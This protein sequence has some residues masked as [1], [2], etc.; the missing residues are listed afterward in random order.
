MATTI[1]KFWLSNPSYW[2]TPAD[3]RSTVDKLIWE[4]WREFDWST[5]DELGQIIY[6][7]QFMR[8]FSRCSVDITEKDVELSRRQAADIAD[9]ADLTRVDS[10]D[11]VW[12]LMPW[13]HLG[14]YQKVFTAIAG[15]QLSDCAELRRFYADTYMKAYDDTTVAAAVTLCDIDE[16]YDAAALC[17]SHPDTINLQSANVSAPLVAPLRFTEPVTISLSGGVDSMLM[18]ALLKR[19]GVD[20]IAVHIVYGNRTIS[21]DE[22]R[23]ISK[24]C[25]RLN[26]PLYVYRI[27]WLRRGLCDRAFYERMTRDLR[28][29]VYRA[30]GRPVLLGH[31]QEDVIENVWTNFAR[32]TN[33][34]NLGKFSMR[35]KESGVDIWRPWLTIS[36][37]LIYSL[38]GSMGI[39]HLKNTT[40]AWSNRG[41]FR[42]QFYGA[43]KE[44]YGEHVDDK[45]LEVAGRLQ[46]QN[47]VIH[48]LVY[49]PIINSWCPKERTLNISGVVGVDLGGD[50]WL[51]IFSDL[52]HN[53]LG[54]SKP[55]YAACVNF[56]K[57]V[58]R[59]LS[60]GQKVVLSKKMV[61]CFCSSASA[62]SLIKLDTL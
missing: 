27:E 38:A 61:A 13:K 47:D 25:L 52:A 59:G 3:Q 18:A 37:E 60:H 11:L 6:L 1:R 51:I 22:L 55:S 16:P 33:L 32:G 7:D 12:W 5:E 40:P 45:I 57:T 28:F 19:L 21:E 48:R 39:P 29:S 20:V 17:E 54:C 53:K 4:Q 24:Y 49:M 35:I 50:A 46:K 8:H 36:K 31:I 58:A 2:I 30:L 41:K 44:Q 14:Q 10:V 34:E 23:F 42:Q 56:S 26:V 62:P 9:K 15:R 43:I